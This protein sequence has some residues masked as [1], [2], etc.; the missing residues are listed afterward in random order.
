MRTIG[1]PLG[2]THVL[3]IMAAM[4][5]QTMRIELDCPQAVWR[6]LLL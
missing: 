2:Q 1:Q 6:D 3:P 5:S 4:T